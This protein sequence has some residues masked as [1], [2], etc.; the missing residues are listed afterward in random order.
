[1]KRRAEVGDKPHDMLSRLQN[2]R[3]AHKFSAEGRCLVDMVTS[4]DSHN[5]RSVRKWERRGGARDVQ[6]RTMCTVTRLSL[7]WVASG[8]RANWANARKP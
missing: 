5:A 4:M 3:P 8:A 6:F 7:T 2:R 1:V